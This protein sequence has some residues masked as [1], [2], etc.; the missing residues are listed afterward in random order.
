MNQNYNDQQ[1]ILIL[2]NGYPSVYQTLSGSFW[3]DQAEALSDQN[4]KVGLIA[5]TPISLKDI[6][7]KGVMNL[8]SKTKIEN[9]VY[10]SVLRFPNIPFLNFLESFFSE[11]FGFYLFKKYIRKN[12]LPDVI[13]VHRYEA[14]LLAYKIKK[15]YKIPYVVTEHSSRFLYETMSK[16]EISIAR[17]VFLNA[18]VCI[19]VSKNL[20]DKLKEICEVSFQYLPNVVDTSFFKKRKELT[21]NALFSFFSAGALDVNKNHKMLI[22]AFY[23]FH[24]QHPN[25]LLCIA[26]EGPLKSSLTSQIEK[27]GLVE[28]VELLGKLDRERMVEYNNKCHVFVLPSFKET[29]GVVLIEAMSTGLPVIALDSGGPSSIITNTQLGE[30]CE[31]NSE[32]LSNA[33]NKVYINFEM[34]SSDYIVNYVN[35]NFS[36]EKV[37]SKLIKIYGQIINDNDRK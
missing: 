20:A 28:S 4:C 10:T 35:E 36:K 13:H 18:N 14:G 32:A 1:H 11:F 3:K 27:L 30:I 7:R 22:D 2:S 17:K 23:L 19:A 16:K 25:S 9:G 8:R 29:F 6:K 33:M 12:G 26:G 21:K 5:T 31:V 24:Q 34:Y 37:I 15:S